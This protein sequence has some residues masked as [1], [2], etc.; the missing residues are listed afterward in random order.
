MCKEKDF[1]SCLRDDS[2]TKL[3]GA[4]LCC[5]QIQYNF[6]QLSGHELAMNYPCQF[7]RR[8]EVHTKRRGIQLGRVLVNASTA[9]CFTIG[10]SSHTEKTSMEILGKK[11]DGL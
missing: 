3:L 9:R 2:L 8:F 1:E 7:K 10:T 6:I 5:I 11:H 4:A